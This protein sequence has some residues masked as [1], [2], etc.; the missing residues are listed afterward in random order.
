[1]CRIYFT[2]EQ[3]VNSHLFYVWWF[4]GFLVAI[5]LGT[6]LA[7]LTIPIWIYIVIVIIYYISLLT[8]SIYYYEKEL[9]DEK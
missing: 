7:I 9:G 5:I 4:T 6:A 2:K 3:M 1:M 8:Y